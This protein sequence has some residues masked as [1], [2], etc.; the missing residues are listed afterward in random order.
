L[1]ETIVASVIFLCIFAM[2]MDTLTRLFTSGH[3]EN[4]FLLIESAMSQHRRALEHQRLKAGSQ[5]YTYKWGELQVNLQRY[6]EQK[7]LF[8]VDMRATTHRKKEIAYRYVTTCKEEEEQTT[9]E[10]EE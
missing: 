9:M 6:G 4:D 3:D 10:G 7:K 1:I 5:S 8:Q 2:T